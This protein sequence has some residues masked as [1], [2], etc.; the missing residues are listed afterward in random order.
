MF[1]LWAIIAL[2]VSDM[3]RFSGV[4]CVSDT[5]YQYQLIFL[6]FVLNIFLGLPQIFFSVCLR[7]LSWFVSNI[8]L[9]LSEI[10]VDVYCVSTPP[11]ALNKSLCQA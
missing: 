7:Y 6:S 5:L 8:C 3:E 4:Y 10:L 1:F 11:A 9:S 2:L